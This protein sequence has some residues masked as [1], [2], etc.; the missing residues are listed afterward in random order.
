MATGCGHGVW[1]QG[2]EFGVRWHN[3]CRGAVSAFDLAWFLHGFDFGVRLGMILAGGRGTSKNR[4][5]PV[6]ESLFSNKANV[7]TL[8][9]LS[10]IL[11][12]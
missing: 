9:V 4:A 1:P 6:V 8:F 3:S 11:K 5:K 12:R 10:E 2:S 7:G